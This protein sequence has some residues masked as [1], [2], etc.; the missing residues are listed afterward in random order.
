MSNI[1]YKKEYTANII[2]TVIDFANTSGGTLYI[3][4][5]D[6]GKAIGVADFDET[7]LKVSNSIRDSIKPDITLFIDYQQET[8]DGKILVKVVVQKGT[9]S[10]YYLTGKGIRPEGIFVRQGAS[11]VPASETAILRMIKETDGEKYEDIRSLNQDLTFIETMKEFK[12]H[13][14]TFEESQQKTLGLVNM[15]GIFTNLGLLLSDQCVHTVKLAVFEG[16]EKAVFKDRREFTGS[17]LKQLTDIYDFIDR[18]NRNRSEVNGLH[19]TDKRDYPVEAVREA[20]L[21]GL[22]A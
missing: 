6:D 4:V 14:I 18:Y 16:T 20:L 1:E 2:K 3:G 15:E 11:T 17:I 5:S 9:S 8:V 21:K 10:P 22:V 13:N 19:R 12:E 7:I